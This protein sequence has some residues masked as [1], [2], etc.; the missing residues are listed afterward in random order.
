MEW[1]VGLSF[2]CVAVTILAPFVFRPHTSR[3]H[4]YRRAGLVLAP[5]TLALWVGFFHL[6]PGSP[7]WFYFPALGVVILVSAG[8]LFAGSVC[9]RERNFHRESLR[10]G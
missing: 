10:D 6:D 8:L 5:L 2:G 9:A 3:W 7:G 1:G 4:R